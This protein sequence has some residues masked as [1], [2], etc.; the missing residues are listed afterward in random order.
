MF[1]GLIDEIR[2]YGSRFDRS[3]V[4]TLEQIR[5]IQQEKA[6]RP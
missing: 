2:V 6:D 4:L 3:G 5:N 1:R